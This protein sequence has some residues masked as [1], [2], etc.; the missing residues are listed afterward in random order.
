MSL[1]GMANPVYITRAR[2]KTAAGAMAY[3]MLGT[4]YYLK[5]WDV[6]EYC[7]IGK[8]LPETACEKALQSIGS[9]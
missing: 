2:I 3:L 7:P 8:V 5:N 1:V 9:T 6:R 4:A